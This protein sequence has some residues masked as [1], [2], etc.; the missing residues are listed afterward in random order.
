MGGG[1]GHMA[2]ACLALG[3]GTLLPLDLPRKSNSELNLPRPNLS[4]TNRLSLMLPASMTVTGN[5]AAT[6][7]F[8]PSMSVSVGGNSRSPN[9]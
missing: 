9:P 3:L 7:V 8:I 2:M 4:A 5:V 1:I 6:S